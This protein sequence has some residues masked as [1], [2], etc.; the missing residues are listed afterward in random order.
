MNEKVKKLLNEQYR[1][2]QLT[3][4]LQPSVERRCTF[5]RNRLERLEL[6]MKSLDPALLL[7]RGYSI[8]LFHGK[9]VRDASLLKKGDELETR[10]AQGRIKSR[11]E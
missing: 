8:T 2:R 4:K 11:V 3:D 10:V 1:L 5:E 6:R 7:R 9:T